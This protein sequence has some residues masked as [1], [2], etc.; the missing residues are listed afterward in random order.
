MKQSLLYNE[1]AAYEYLGNFER[2]KVLMD[3]YLGKYPD[4]EKALREAGFLSTR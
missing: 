3:K 2:A 4:D 1:I